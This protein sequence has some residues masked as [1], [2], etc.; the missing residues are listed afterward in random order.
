VIGDVLRDT[1]ALMRATVKLALAKLRARD[2][3]PH[4][5]DPRFEF[6]TRCG[7]YPRHGAS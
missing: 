1:W 4:E 3:P 5:Y 6:C 7:E 2:C